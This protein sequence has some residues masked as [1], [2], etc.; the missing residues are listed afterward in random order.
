[1]LLSR[2]K[3]RSEKAGLEPGTLVHVGEAPTEQV[4]ITIREYDAESLIEKVTDSPEECV[5]FLRSQPVTWLHVEGIYDP[6]VMQRIGEAFELHP[7][8]MEDILNTH[9]RPKTEEYDSYCFIVLKMLCETG[10]DRGLV[11]R[12][13]SFVLGA[14]YLL[15][16]VE[17]PTPL[18]D[19]IIERLRAN[20]GRLRRQGADSLAYALIDAVVDSYFHV[21]ERLA[22]ETEDLEE[23]LV[24][25]PKPDILRR[26]NQLKRDSMLFRRA[27]WPLREVISTLIKTET[28]LVQDATR[29]YLRDV[30]DHAMQTIDASEMIRERVSELVDVYLSSISN[31]LNSVMKVL[32]IITT[33][34]IPL[35]FVAGVY[36]MNFRYMPEL[37]AENGYFVVLG[38]MGTLA[39]GMTWLF[40]RKG[41]W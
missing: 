5:T 4:R 41:W 39:L 8:V 22:D 11:A 20:K 21:L 23:E 36:G 24:E 18:F 37:E 13:V 27:A 6:A 12:Q 29:L 40:K 17:H 25:K 1:M 15:S 7:L 19:P 10:P 9:Q 26:V 31:H 30:A 16:F 2:A 38:I 3:K 33:I 34:F 35:S 28:D 32:T 14:N